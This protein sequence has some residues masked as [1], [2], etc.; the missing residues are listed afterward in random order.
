MQSHLVAGTGTMYV[1]VLY[2]G[3]FIET[4]FQLNLINIKLLSIFNTL[5]P[6]HI[7]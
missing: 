6:L 7:N 1:Q 3:I 4:G 2:L 5:F